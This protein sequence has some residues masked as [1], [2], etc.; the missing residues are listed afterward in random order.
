[1]DHWMN[2]CMMASNVSHWIMNYFYGSM[3][4]LTSNL[5]WWI[6]LT[7]SINLCLL[8][9]GSEFNF[10]YESMNEWISEEFWPSPPASP[11]DQWLYL[12]VTCM[13]CAHGLSQPAFGS[14]TDLTH[15]HII[16]Y[17][18]VCPCVCVAMLYYNTRVCWREEHCLI[19]QPASFLMLAMT[20]E[21]CT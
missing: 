1:M 8:M 7:L 17:I 6:I 16:I 13:V 12:L 9:F 21:V 19:L 3:N 4:M 18:C 14:I 10:S 5:R 2:V 11:V 15:V 20:V